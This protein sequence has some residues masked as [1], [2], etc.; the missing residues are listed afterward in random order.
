LIGYVA[1]TGKLDSQAW[2]L[3]A[4][5]FLWQFPH[6]MAIAWMYR[7]DYARA[8]YQVLPSGKRKAS[9]MAWQSV[10]PTLA[11]VLVTVTPSALEHA[12][13]V[14][15]AG[16]FFAQRRF[17]LF[18][19][20]TRADSLKPVCAPAAFC[21]DRLPSIGFCAS[22]PG[23]SLRQT[24]LV[25]VPARIIYFATSC[26]RRIFTQAGVVPDSSGSCHMR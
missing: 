5:L 11:L 10:L 20:A 14:F 17:P 26:F 8:G 15:V 19:R 21:L 7:E 16:T 6:F 2:L 23:K 9:F 24:A 12:T 3:Y 25:R 13:L 1:A 4:V 22:N 18:C